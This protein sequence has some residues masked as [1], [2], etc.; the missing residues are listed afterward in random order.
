MMGTMGARVLTCGAM[1]GRRRACLTPGMPRPLGR[2]TLADACSPNLKSHL[3]TRTE[4]TYNR[5]ETQVRTRVC[6]LG[7]IRSDGLG[8]SS[9]FKVV[10]LF[11]TRSHSAET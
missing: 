3:S 1:W 11:D 5:Q 10:R 2:A 4:H 7:M 9:R 8:D 6:K